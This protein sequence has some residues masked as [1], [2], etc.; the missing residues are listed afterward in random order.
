MYRFARETGQKVSSSLVHETLRYVAYQ[1]RH[2]PLTAM[3][4]ALPTWDRTPRLDSWLATWAGATDTPYTRLAGR[5][6]LLGA[7]ARAYRPGVK[8]DLV[9]ILHG[10]QGLGKSRL[11]ADLAGPFFNDASFNFENEQKAGMALRD[12]WIHEWSEL[13]SMSKATHTRLKSFVSECHNRFRPPYGREMVVEPRRCV[14]AGSSN[15]DDF[16]TDTTGN[17][18]FLPVAVTEYRRDAFLNARE[19]LLAEAREAHLNG[20][21]HHLNTAEEATA[22]E[23]RDLVSMEDVWSP[24]IGKWLASQTEISIEDALA[25]VG[26]MPDRMDRKQQFRMA[27]I[28]RREGW[29][30][31]GRRDGHRTWKRAIGGLRSMETAQTS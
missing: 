13:D 26:I 11:L 28:L 23:P 16:L 19:Q 4:D 9:L 29:A 20:E 10:F 31:I 12:T 3:L 22:R 5:R 25:H 17:R 14:F 21:R 6:W 15:K 27:D 24:R 7:M 1:H 2:D 30:Q 8:A 18:R